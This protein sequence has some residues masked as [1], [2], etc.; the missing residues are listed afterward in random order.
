[1]LADETGF[2]GGLVFK[3]HR[4]VS[5]NSRLESN[6]EEEEGRYRG[7]RVLNRTAVPSRTGRDTLLGQTPGVLAPEVDSEYF[8]LRF[9]L[10]RT[11]RAL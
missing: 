2:R 6:K 8:S 11:H 5:L 7:Q 9:R 4:L 3:A 10:S 1:M